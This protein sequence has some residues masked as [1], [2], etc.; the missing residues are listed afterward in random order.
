VLHNGVPKLVEVCTVQ[1]GHGVPASKVGSAITF[2]LPHG[3]GIGDGVGVGEAG[4][5]GVGEGP[6][7][8]KTVKLSIRQPADA[9]LLSEARRN[10]KIPP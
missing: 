8:E 4:G 10:R 7:V 1:F 5:V 3:E 9:P 2:G 6:S